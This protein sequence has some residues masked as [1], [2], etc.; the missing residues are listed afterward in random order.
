[1]VVEKYKR[2][3]TTQGK[4]QSEYFPGSIGLENERS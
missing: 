2:E 4:A 1:M 3:K